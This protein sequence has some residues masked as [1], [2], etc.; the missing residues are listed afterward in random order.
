MTAAAIGAFS[1]V[2]LLF[3]LALRIPVALSLIGVSFLGIWGARGWNPAWGVLKSVPYEFVSNWTLTS[4]PMFVLMGYVGF[5]SGIT[6]GLFN[7][8]KALLHRLPGSLAI[9]STFACTAFASMCGSSVACAAAMG[10]IAIPEMVA[11]GYNRNLACGAIAAGG[12]LGALIPPSIL[13]ILFG[14]IAQV[15]IV[16][17]FISGFI[18]GI[19]SAVA[20]VLIFL[21]FAWLRPDWVPRRL[22]STDVPSLKQALI[23]TGPALLIMVATFGGMFG[24]IFTATEAGAVGAFLSLVYAFVSGRIGRDKVNQALVDTVMTCGALFLI[25]VGAIMLTRL[26][27]ISGLGMTISSLVHAMEL[28]YWQLMLMIVALYLVLGMFLDPFGAMLITLPIF[29]PILNQ[30]GID[31]VFFGIFMVKMLEIGMLTPPVGMNVFVI[32]S[33]VGNLT[34]LGGIF[35]GVAPF[36]IVDLLVV[37]LIVAYP[38]LALL[39]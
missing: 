6:S 3:L 37:A 29:L 2:G 16:E 11:A 7:L 14:V 36:F 8:A 9:S 1:V 15:S 31:L 13:M 38:S 4:V 22:Q 18:I 19:L 28:S 26:L 17:L 10:R 5:Y 25:G 23:D 34:N 32:K 30:Y 39:R 35:R 24:G 20:Y 12:T 27:S 21:V 33:V